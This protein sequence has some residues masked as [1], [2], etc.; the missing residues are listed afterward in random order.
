MGP[1]RGE[2]QNSALNAGGDAVRAKRREPSFAPEERVFLEVLCGYNACNLFAAMGA[3]T[4]AKAL[5][6][7]SADYGRSV[8]VRPPPGL[9]CS[10]YPFS[11]SGWFEVAR[12]RRW[13]RPR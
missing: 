9:R 13:G 7:I 4:D 1:V 12:L 8:V 2:T 5:A 3:A 11:R 10:T 6:S